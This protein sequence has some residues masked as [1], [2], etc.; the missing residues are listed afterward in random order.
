M[1]Y[2]FLLI[3]LI[4]FN[5]SMLNANFNKQSLPQETWSTI[6]SIGAA[7]LVGACGSYLL[8][9]S[10]RYHEKKFEDARFQLQIRGIIIREEKNFSADIVRAYGK[11]R[12]PET[13]N[14]LKQLRASHEAKHF[15]EQW[16]QSALV[17]TLTA[18]ISAL[19]MSKNRLMH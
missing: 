4:A 3:P 2:K 17:I 11:V 15:R 19:L 16:F 1:Q 9:K 18:G 13:E 14:Y 8:Y 12:H 6:G 7:G 5:H 10:K